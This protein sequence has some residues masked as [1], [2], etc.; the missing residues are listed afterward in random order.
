LS[1]E[2]VWEHASVTHR[3]HTRDISRSGCLVACGQAV[4]VGEVIGLRLRRP[5]G[6][7]LSLRAAVVDHRPGLGFGV[8][9]I[10]PSVE[11]RAAITQ[12]IVGHA[13]GLL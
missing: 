12:L 8:R 6:S 5:Q 10:D 3:A 1:V 4:P 2:V 9:F 13:S 11:E 7:W